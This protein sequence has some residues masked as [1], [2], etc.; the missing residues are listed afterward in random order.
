MRFYKLTHTHRGRYILPKNKI[1]YVVQKIKGGT[2]PLL[3]NPA[4]VEQGAGMKDLTSKLERL[5]IKK[6]GRRRNIK[7]VL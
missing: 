7:F 6:G 1:N 3:L 5:K 4:L 2:V